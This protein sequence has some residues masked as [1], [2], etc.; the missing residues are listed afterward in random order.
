[1]NILDEI[2]NFLKTKGIFGKD[3]VRDNDV[4]ISILSVK[5]HIK[6]QINLMNN[7][8][9]KEWIKRVCNRRTF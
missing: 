2:I 1:M 6:N 9:E 7:G 5:D 4:W 8:D 3:W